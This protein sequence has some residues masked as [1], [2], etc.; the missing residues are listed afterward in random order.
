LPQ[1]ACLVIAQTAENLP[2][3]FSAD[4]S[5]SEKAT[6]WANHITRRDHLNQGRI[7]RLPSYQ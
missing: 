3:A 1:T 6:V 2:V 7:K 4:R 5:A